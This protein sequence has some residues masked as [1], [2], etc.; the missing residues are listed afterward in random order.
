MTATPECDFC[1]EAVHLEEGVWVD[2]TGGDV[3]SGDDNLEN[4]NEQHA[5]SG[6]DVCSPPEEEEL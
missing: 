4:E 3:C 5:P 2:A 1:G 6:D